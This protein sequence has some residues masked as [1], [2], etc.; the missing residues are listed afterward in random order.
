MVFAP[1]LLA[2][3][4]L[5]GVPGP[6]DYFAITVVDAETGRGVPLVELRTVN[7]IRHVTDSNGIVA[8]HE[9]GLMG[10]DVF[11][12]VCSHG[13]E[14]PK[15]GFGIRGKTLRVVPGGS[16]KL[17]IQ[18]INIAERLYRITGGGIYRDSPLVGARVP[19]KEPVLNGLVL[20]SDS[21]VNVVYRN[22]IYWFWGDTTR[23]SYPL[24]NFHV[25]GATSLL[26]G[27]GGLDP[28]VGVDLHYFTDAK[29]FAKEMARLPGKGP[30]WLTT[31]AVVA[32]KNG[33]ERLVGSYVKV[34]PPLEVYA[35]GLAVFDDGAAKFE[36]LGEFDMKAPSFPTGPSFIHAANGVKHVYFARPFPVVRVRATLEDFRRVEAFESFT[37]LKDGTR[38]E[39]A[40]LD[41]DA[42]GKLRY[43]WRK[44]TPAL[45]QDDEA[46]LIEAGA[47]KPEEA[48]WQ[49]RERGTGKPVSAH[50]GSVSWNA[51]RG[52]WVMIAVQQ[53]GTSALGEVWF[54]EAD[55]PVG[56]WRDA[57]KVVTHDRYSFYNPKQ[58]PMFDKDG[59]RFI[60]FEGT[61][62]HTFSGNTDATPRYDYNQIMYKLDLAHPRLGLAANGK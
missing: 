20:G 45:T 24:G 56:P 7:G 13:Y 31:A 48:R 54:A 10:K 19:L 37:C 28:E 1:L 5:R 53:W 22:K 26:P 4:A 11:F 30:T 3:A 32:D 46:K 42:E 39:E 8:F 36:P 57:V 61:Y 40:Q 55:S 44:R 17:T 16:A 9:P 38:R 25:P 23:P 43:A 6:A 51:Y 60:V 35:R 29:G 14:F 59:G 34:K 27:H 15:D 49:L 12:H 21:V 41:R 50:A 18:R 58:H 52:R 33:R 2:V 47:V 62:T